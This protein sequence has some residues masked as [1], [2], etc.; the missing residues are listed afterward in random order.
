MI[1]RKRGRKSR[2]EEWRWGEENIEVVKEYRYLGYT[3]TSNNKETRHIQEVLG[4]ANRAIGQIWSIGERKFKTNMKIRL[5]MFDVLIKSIIFY[6]VQVWGWKEIKEIEKIQ[7]KY[8]KWILGLDRNTPSYIV[9]EETKREWLRVESG[10]RAVK[11]EKHI[12]FDTE[13]EILRE[14]WKELVRREERN[15]ETEYD[16][17]RRSYYERC[18]QGVRQISERTDY[19]QK[20]KRNNRQRHSNTKTNTIQQHRENKI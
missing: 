8:L 3:M 17:A 13:N 12:R 10:K 6:G 19:E 2:E 1:F 9:L 7:V 16:K 15:K 11:Y 18:G 4:K 14:T 20:Y 5:M